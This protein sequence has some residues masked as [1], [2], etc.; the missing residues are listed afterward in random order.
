MQLKIKKMLLGIVMFA[1]APLYAMTDTRLTRDILIDIDITLTTCCAA[2][3]TDFNGTFTVLTALEQLVASEIGGTFITQAMVGTTGFTITSSGVYKLAQNITF[4]PIA[5]AVAITINADNVCLDLR[6]F[7]ITQGNGQINVDAIV[8]GINHKNILISN[9]YI[10]GMTNNGISLGAGCSNFLMNALQIRN[11]SQGI[12]VASGSSNLFMNSSKII[13]CLQGIVFNGTALSPIVTYGLVGLDL[14][15]NGTGGNFTFASRGSIA[16]CNIL[17]SINAGLSFV[18]SFSNNVDNCIINNTK[19]TTGSAVGISSALGGSN[20]FQ[21]CIID[22]TSTNDTF[23]GN[24][25]SGILIGNTE[26]N[27]TIINNEVTNCI[28]TSNAQPYGIQMQYTFTNVLTTAGLPTFGGTAN[29]STVALDVSPNGRFIAYITESSISTF[30]PLRL[31]ILEYNGNSLI[32]VAT[33]SVPGSGSI[34]NAVPKVRWSHDGQFLAVGQGSQPDAFSPISGGISIFSFNSSTSKLTFLDDNIIVGRIGYDVSWSP[35]DR[36]FAASVSTTAVDRIIVFQFDGAIFTQITSLVYSIPSSTVDWSSLGSFIATGGTPSSPTGMAILSFDGAALTSVATNN[37]V[38]LSPSLIR[39]AADG[40]TLGV[41]AL[42][43]F[44]C[45][46]NGTTISRNAQISALCNMLDISA[47][48]QFLS[49]ISGGAKQALKFTGNGFTRVD[50]G[51]G[52]FLTVIAWSPDG[53]YV[54]TDDPTFLVRINRGLTFPR[55][56]LINN[57]VTNVHGLS[58]NTFNTGHGLSSSSVSSLI[59]QNTAFNNDVNYVFADNVFM[60][61]SVFEP[62]D[63]NLIQNLS[64]PPL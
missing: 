36:Y 30:N 18:S 16:D 33:I 54:V 37:L 25:A 28:T 43:V 9:G 11:C 22:G 2:L 31:G 48:G 49:I 53:S 35:D 23:T 24:T 17:N 39:F 47:D 12:S 62:S 1:Y 57:T 4:S 10:V 50:N 63:P 61:Y 64:F 14:L 13:S 8:V 60:Q 42:D 58:Q 7:T 32:Q 40:R 52:P 6:C 19:A 38:G 56:T 21:N 29:E 15:S 27:D 59:M 3:Q 45:Y 26:K 51:G 5:P 34:L 44:S 41:A 46:F 55:N 20:N